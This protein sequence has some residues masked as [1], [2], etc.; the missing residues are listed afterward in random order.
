[1][2]TRIKPDVLY[3]E[4]EQITAILTR[5]KTMLNDGVPGDD[6]PSNDVNIEVFQVQL[7]AEIMLASGRLATIAEV[8]EG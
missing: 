5:V 1:M 2:Y 4:V 8:L 7:H 3:D 6:V